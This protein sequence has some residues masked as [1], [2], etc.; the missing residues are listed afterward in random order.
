MLPLVLYPAGKDSAGAPITGF[1][2][3][4][5]FRPHTFAALAAPDYVQIEFQP[6]GTSSW[7]PLG[8]L[9]PTVNGHDFF[10]G[11]VPN[12]GPGLIRA[13]WRA[14]TAPFLVMSRSAPVPADATPYQLTP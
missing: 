11:T 4:L 8:P 14:H 12:P 9:V 10:L 7:R 13:T 5:R 1:W 6:T 3:Q 2:G